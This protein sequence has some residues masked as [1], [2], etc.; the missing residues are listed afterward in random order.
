MIDRRWS[1]IGRAFGIYF[2]ISLWPATFPF[3]PL[4]HRRCYITFRLYLH[5]SSMIHKLETIPRRYLI[6]DTNR[7][8]FISKWELKYIAVTKGSIIAI[9]KTNFLSFVQQ[10]GVLLILLIS[11]SLSFRIICADLMKLCRKLIYF[12][13]N[14]FSYQYI[15]LQVLLLYLHSFREI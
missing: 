6:H 8:A 5:L 4:W 9:F 7:S 12:I 11:V 15:E 1:G 2:L 13:F 3:S 10:F 14:I